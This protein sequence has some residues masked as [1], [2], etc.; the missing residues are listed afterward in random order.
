MRKNIYTQ[1]VDGIKA[2]DRAVRKMLE[3]AR[4]FDKKEKIINMK[5]LRY[6]VI[7]ASLAAVLALG[8]VF[9]LSQLTPKSDKAAKNNGFFVTAYAAEQVK[10]LDDISFKS[11]GKMECKSSGALIEDDMPAFISASF[12]AEFKCEGKEIESLT[13]KISSTDS[14]PLISLP[15]NNVVIS[16][17]GKSESYGVNKYCVSETSNGVK[18]Y[19]YKE[20]TV[21]Y[22]NQIKGGRITVWKKTAQEEKKIAKA[23]LIDYGNEHWASE[24][25]KTEY[26]KS[27]KEYTEMFLKNL[28]LDITANFK[29]GGKLTK[30]VVF[31]SDC[32][33]EKTMLENED[34][35]KKAE[36]YDCLP[37]IKAK[38]I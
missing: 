31:D 11:I 17:K 29:N 1:A 27:C 20:V 5:K 38:L 19:F 24:T 30:T 25:D 2:P 10:Q 9:G 37:A 33:V 35:G 8:G 26:E 23:Y 36:A 14:E 34:T 15:K 7:A 32:R 21:P 16:S 28:K 4:G 6:G 3:T 18:Y 13:Y 12:N 22:N